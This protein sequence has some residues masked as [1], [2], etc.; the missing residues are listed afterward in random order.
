MKVPQPDSAYLLFVDEKGMARKVSLSAGPDE[1]CLILPKNRVTPFLFFAGE[2]DTRPFGS[3]YPYDTASDKAGGF[4][5]FI[6]YRLFICSQND[7][8][9]IYE[10]I[11]YFNWAKLKA[12]VSVYEEPW[13]LDDV[14]IAE[15][16]AEGT[17]NSR[18]IK[19]KVQ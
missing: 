19:K 5:A 9:T 15:K 13:A 10:R 7:S 8:Q 18:H 4:T 2:A 12:A 6:L 17:F 16:I 14:L 1:I 11:R 3:V